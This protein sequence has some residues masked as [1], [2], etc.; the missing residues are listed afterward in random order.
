MDVTMGTRT[1][2]P[3]KN[4]DFFR[5]KSPGAIADYPGKLE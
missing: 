4:L 2:K 1:F 5:I 3:R